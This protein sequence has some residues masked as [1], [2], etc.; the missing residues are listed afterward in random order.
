[1]DMQTTVKTQNV[2]VNQQ[3]QTLA[4]IYS[5]HKKQNKWIMMIDA[6]DNALKS[7]SQ[8]NDINTKK[9][10]KVHSNKVKVH[11]ESIEKALKRGNCSAV[12][13]CKQ[14]FAQSQI[15]KLSKQAAQSNTDFI[16]LNNL[17]TVH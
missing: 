6:E 9:I 7:L 16:V 17:T 11:A 8:E 10:L 13:L 14:L 5:T 3:T 15:D 1:M 4:N 12:V 2:L